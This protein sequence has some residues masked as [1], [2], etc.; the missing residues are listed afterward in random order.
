[1]NLIARFAATTA[2]ALSLLAMPLVASADTQADATRLRDSRTAERFD[3]PSDASIRT[4]GAQIFVNAP[5]SVVRQIVTD[6]AHYQDFMPGFKR[7]RIVQHNKDFSDVYLQ[8]PILHGAATVWAVTRFA[9][10]VR[11][12]NGTEVI[13]GTMQQGNVNDFHATW[14][15]IPVDADHTILRSELLIVPKLPL[16][17]S[18]VTPELSYAADKAV[19]ATR[20]R[21]ETDATRV[22]SANPA[23][24]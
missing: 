23:T 13:D 17:T 7:S 14:R 4:G 1:M 9:K 12:A 10:P 18:V 5:L 6:Y 11:Q 19:T 2:T 21:A 22:A 24:P 20:T 8:V 15:L 3:Q 16:P